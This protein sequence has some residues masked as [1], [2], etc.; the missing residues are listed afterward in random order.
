MTYY[1]LF[2]LNL[3]ET[4][5]K[6]L[7]KKQI[8]VIFLF[9]FKIGY[10]AADTTHNIN[11]AFDPRT[12][13]EHR[14]QRWFKKFCKG[15]KGLEE[16]ERGDQSLEVENNQLRGSLKLILLELQEKLLK[17]SVSTIHGHLAFE[18]N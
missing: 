14:M 5:E 7:D 10:K 6:M 17:N 9:K 2:I 12:T 15:D 3:F 11:N 16:E 18:A 8:P 13:N 4:I 1:L